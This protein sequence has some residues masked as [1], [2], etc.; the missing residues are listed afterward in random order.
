MTKVGPL[1]FI[2][3]LFFFSY[4]ASAQKIKYK[5]IF[6]LLSTKQYEQA[7]PFL[8]KYLKE[9]DD[10]PN[11]YLYMG[12][13]F[14]EKSAK[15]DLLKQTNLV[16]SYID[17]S[18]FHFDKA[19]QT[20]DDRELRKNK[21]YYQ[22]YNRRDLR[23]GEFG[24]K[25]SD[26]QFDVEKKI[27]G[28]KERI[29][30]VKMVKHYFSQADT[31][32]KKCNSL[33]ATLGK[34]Y[35]L[36][37]QLYLR[38]NEGVVKSL[39]LLSMQYDSCIKAFENYKSVS[40]TLGRTGY[41]QNLIIA[42]INDY[43]KEGLTASD[44]YQ[45]E[46]KV[47]DYKKFA[48][49]VRVVIEKEIVPMRAHLISYDVEINKLR[50]RLNTDSV[51]VKS[52]LTKLID[53][54]LY[55]QLQKFDPQPL[56]IEVFSM[57]TADLEYRSSLLEHK[58]L[59]DSSDVHYQLK[60]LK[61]EI[62][63]LDKLD[64]ISSKL[65][66]SNI[67]QR[68][69]DYEFFITNTYSNAT[70]LQSYVSTLSEYAAREKKIKSHELLQ[71]TEALNWIVDGSDSI[72]LKTD[73]Q[74]LKYKALFTANENFTVGLSIKDSLHSDGY[75][76]C[77]TQSRKA[78]TK[79]NFPLD[80]S[81]FKQARLQQTKVLTYADPSGQVYY[82]LIYGELPSKEKYPATLAKIYKSDGL[83]WSNNVQLAFIPKEITFKPET[84]ELTIKDEAKLLVIDKNGKV[85]R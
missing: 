7:E 34:T 68:S 16:L 52:D 55:E 45:N 12:I 35:P 31:L 82:V 69:M 3:A 47:W 75:F 27:Q 21:E 85:L 4:T 74:T 66:A 1:P 51:S 24:V 18:I 73:H 13:L 25:L 48:E 81:S 19:Y 32:Y 40:G 10:N 28:Q 53:K 29:D 44:F 9:N 8:K 46:L 58:V 33:Y 22:A 63:F 80:K 50:D 41:N 72:P 49:K 42:E 26:I 77:V 62:R 56:P 59:K 64:S 20:I 54:L 70:V 5:D 65:V 71:Y 6:G 15:M 14:Q 39:V 83:A 2:I 79:V 61:N 57:K 67:E 30:R 23:T 76:Y 11:A 38:S 43:Q 36:E 17:S 84:S 37:K 60:L 78:G